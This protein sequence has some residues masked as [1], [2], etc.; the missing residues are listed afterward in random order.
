MG[1]N[2]SDGVLMGTR[3][4]VQYYRKGNNIIEKKHFW[5]NLVLQELFSLFQEFVKRAN[6]LLVLLLLCLNELK[7]EKLS[8]NG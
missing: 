6:K 1:A 2:K 5:P 4:P 8:T 7:T 3:V